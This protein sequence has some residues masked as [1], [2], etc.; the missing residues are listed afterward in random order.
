MFGLQWI[1]NTVAEVRNLLQ[2]QN[3]FAVRDGLRSIECFRLLLSRIL[4]VSWMLLSCFKAFKWGI[5]LTLSLQHD[6][7]IFQKEACLL[8]DAFFPHLLIFSELIIY[9]PF[10]ELLQH[11]KLIMIITSY[12]FLLG[13]QSRHLKLLWVL[14]C[15][16]RKV[17]AILRFCGR[18]SYI[19]SKF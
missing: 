15:W 10:W 3:F 14:N 8:K 12:F 19:L 11:T 5:G 6:L 13:F 1:F 4:I 17:L 18:G 9:S 2:L 7:P 16:M